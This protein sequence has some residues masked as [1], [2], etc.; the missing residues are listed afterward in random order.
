MFY[1]PWGLKDKCV[2]AF[3]M[4]NWNVLS[5]KCFSF[6]LRLRSEILEIDFISTTKFGTAISGNTIRIRIRSKTW[7]FG[8]NFV[9]KPWKGSIKGY[10]ILLSYRLYILGRD[11]TDKIKIWKRDAAITISSSLS[12]K[13][14]NFTLKTHSTSTY[15]W[16]PR[17]IR[18][19]YST[20]KWR[21][22]LNSRYRTRKDQ[23]E[24]LI[25][26]GLY[27]GCVFLFVINKFM[28]ASQAF[29]GQHKPDTI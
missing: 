16:K 9:Q 4:L 3:L 14:T 6:P 26:Y 21:F 17:L 29:P 18:K 27:T 7:I 1:V 22:V 12:L 15:T 19:R 24:W 13:E 25:S 2:L 20:G 8:S 11:K 5:I 10:H 28:F 23:M